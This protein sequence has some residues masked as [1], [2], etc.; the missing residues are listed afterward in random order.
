MPIDPKSRPKGNQ[1]P[2]GAITD[3]YRALALARLE[4]PVRPKVIRAS[5]IGYQPR[6]LLM[7]LMPGKYPQRP[8]DPRGMRTFEVGDKAQDHLAHAALSGGFDGRLAL[9]KADEEQVRHDLGNGWAI[10][11]HMDGFA[12]WVRHRGGNLEGGVVIDFKTTGSFG[13]RDVMAG[14]VNETYIA[15]LQAYMAMKGA[16]WGLLI[17]ERKDT[18]ALTSIAFPFNAE[19]WKGL[20]ERA[21]QVAAFAEM[22]HDPMSL[23]PCSGEDYGM[24]KFKSCD[25]PKLGWKCSY[26]PFWQHCFQDAVSARVSGSPHV[27]SEADFALHLLPKGRE[28]IEW[29]H[30]VIPLDGWRLEGRPER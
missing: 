23:L 17:Y 25:Y 27:V 22:G 15:Q 16:K 28:V 9:R 6:R 29:G 11:G 4:E 14:K 19:S 20:L 2:I 12:E 10:V 5:G 21:R 13:W 24:V 26:C 8:T 3:H 7:G 18:Q 1:D 30:D